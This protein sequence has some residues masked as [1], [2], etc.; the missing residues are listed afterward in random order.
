MPNPT[1]IPFRP[2]RRLASAL[3]LAASSALAAF[4]AA[5]PAAL[6]ASTV[7]GSG[8]AA[9]QT[10][11]PGDFS[12]IAVGGGIDLH[13]RQ[14]AASQLTLTAD[15]NLLPLIETVV[16]EGRHGRTLRIGFARGQSIRPRTDVTVTVDVVQLRAIAS[17]GSGDVRVG[18]L[19]TPSLELTLAGSSDAQLDG[20]RTDALTVSISGS[21]DLK[22]SGS[23]A[24]VE[25]SISGSSDA[26][27]DA[28]EADVVEISIA[29]SGDATV[30]A[31]QSLK[32]GVAGSGEVRY[33]GSPQVTSS[34][35][36]SGSVRSR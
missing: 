25:L 9:T 30:H 28:L 12:A 2:L 11:Q 19:D 32:V 17:A 7:V 22:A 1:P 24:R 33:R 20:L 16:A 3:L 13:V 31:R 10:R 5:P 23:A 35:A 21:G 4:A 36:G 14:A 15:D 8:T 26:E 29:G 18:R 6:A 34:I 27:L